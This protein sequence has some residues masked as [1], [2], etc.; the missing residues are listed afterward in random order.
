MSTLVRMELSLANMPHP[1][2]FLCNDESVRSKSDIKE[3]KQLSRMSA[4]AIT[5]R[6]RD[7]KIKW[8]RKHRETVQ[9]FSVVPRPQ[10]VRML[11]V[12]DLA[13]EEA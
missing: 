1:L 3:V 12:K 9:Y 7:K 2:F 11:W 8:L 10:R 5:A 13:K 6:E 4:S